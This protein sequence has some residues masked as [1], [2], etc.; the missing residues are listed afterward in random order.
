ME[1][2][3]DADNGGQLVYLMELARVMSA[4]PAVTSLDIFTRL[5]EDP[6]VEAVYSKEIEALSPKLC[7]K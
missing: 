5:I 2:G 1:I 3:R 6:Q 7:I 4:H